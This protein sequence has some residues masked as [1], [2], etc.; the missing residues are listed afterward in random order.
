[1]TKWLARAG[2]RSTITSVEIEKETGKSVWLPNGR[3]TAKVGDFGRYFDNW[4]EAHVW[5]SQEAERLVECARRRLDD[6]LEHCLDVER[7]KKQ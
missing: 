6:A 2:W 5:L 1:M 7:M 3:R 4:E